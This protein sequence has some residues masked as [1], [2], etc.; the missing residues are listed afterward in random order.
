MFNVRSYFS[1]GIEQ[2]IKDGLRSN[3]YCRY[4]TPLG[5]NY[6]SIFISGH[7]PMVTFGQ[8]LTIQECLSESSVIAEDTDRQQAECSAPGS[9]V[10]PVFENFEFSPVIV[11]PF[12]R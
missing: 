6:S 5:S 3:R 10:L 8:Y 2:K 12:V 7:A 1:L 9:A 4:M 11:N